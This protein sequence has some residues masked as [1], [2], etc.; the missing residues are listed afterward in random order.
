MKKIKHLFLLLMIMFSLLSYI[1]TY[2]MG[3]WI[4]N[5]KIILNTKYVYVGDIFFNE[6]DMK[7]K[8]SNEDFK[9]K[10]K[11][12]GYIKDY[13]YITGD[14]YNMNDYSLDLRLVNECDFKYQEDNLKFTMNKLENKEGQDKLLDVSLKIKDFDEILL[15]KLI[16][17]CE[18]RKSKI[19][20]LK[21]RLLE[22]ITSR[23]SM[24]NE[25][26]MLSKELKL[27]NKSQESIGG[28]LK[29]T[30]GFMKERESL[31]E[32][33]AN[34][35]NYLK[36]LKDK[37]RI[38][39][40]KEK[41]G[42]LFLN[43][44]YKDISEK[45]LQKMKLLRIKEKELDLIEKE[46]KRN[47]ENY[48]MKESDIINKQKSLIEIENI[49]NKIGEEKVKFEYEL[50]QN[51]NNKITLENEIENIKNENL[52]L[53]KNKKNI[54][55]NL[56]EFNSKKSI[57][58]KDILIQK[59]NIQEID[60]KINDLLA[61]RKKKVD[62]ISSIY[63]NIKTYDDNISNLDNE[64]NT[65]IYK[66]NYNKIKLESKEKKLKNIDETNLDL[67]KQLNNTVRKYRFYSK[68]IHSTMNILNNTNTDIDMLKS[69]IN[70]NKLNYEQ[71][72]KEY[73]ELNL[74]KDKLG[75]KLNSI[76]IER[77]RLEGNIKSHEI[78][79]DN[80]DHEIRKMEDN[81]GM[82]RDLNSR[83]NST[84]GGVQYIDNEY[85]KDHDKIENQIKTVRDKLDILK[86]SIRENVSSFAD[87]VED[88][89]KKEIPKVKI[90]IEL[91]EQELDSISLNKLSMDKIKTLIDLIK[92]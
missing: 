45:Y 77:K 14:E 63:D 2:S 8:L 84:Y 21:N 6:K 4:K 49:Y 52:L 33:A 56:E 81:M 75:S 30:D 28:Y 17:S 87:L 79:I 20:S 1:Y 73:G 34:Q 90:I 11:F 35:M 67:N 74:Y 37:T 88:K 65:L 51:N 15:K 71:T 85:R 61:E 64:M 24:G 7:I 55:L 36:G 9:N 3:K 62:T 32:I 53:Q 18:N 54:F 60:K 91:I 59:E 78:Q 13:M 10:N 57:Q 22:L 72:N 27:K 89:V 50:K 42:K 92:S 46:T 12:R 16:Q 44:K 31:K 86:D 26:E 41:T 48:N 69:D 19:R 23:V 47:N 38:L 70:K 80:Y 66:Q 82:N 68:N 76:D 83:G 25:I 5:T 40:E 39:I 43:D 29:E 58:E